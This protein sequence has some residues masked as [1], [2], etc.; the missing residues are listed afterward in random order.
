MM[1]LLMCVGDPENP[2]DL[3]SCVWRFQAV[4]NANLHGISWTSQHKSQLQ[5]RKK[6]QATQSQVAKIIYR[7]T[8]Q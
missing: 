4:F 1:F 6:I 7:L 8:G 2:R 3:C 5:H